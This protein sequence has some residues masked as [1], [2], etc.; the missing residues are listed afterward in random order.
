MIKTLFS[1]PIRLYKIVLSPFLPRACI[2]E[3]T[4]SEYALLAID[5]FG[6]IK[7]GAL[8]AKRI[9]KCNPFHHGGDDPVP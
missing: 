4:C 1:L 2:F 8:A 9:L 7:G 3:P 5:K 6:P